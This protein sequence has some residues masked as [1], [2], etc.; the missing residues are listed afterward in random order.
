MTLQA[1][2]PALFTANSSHAPA[3][4]TILMATRNGEK[5][6]SEQ[7]DSI[8]EQT[9]GDWSLIV[10]DDGSTDATRDRVAAFAER[11]RSKRILRLD[12]PRQGSAMNF[13][14]LLRA[15]GD[16]PWVA[17][18]DQDDV[19]LPD[20]LSRGLNKLEGVRGPALYG[21]RTM[22]TDAQLRP[23]R[24][25]PDFS[26]PKSFGN[27]LVQSVAGGNTMLINRAA[28]DVLQPASRPVQRLIAHDW[29]TYQMITAI[30]GTVVYDKVPTV[31]SRQHTNNQI[32]ANDTWRASLRRVS[33][34]LS[35]EFSDW[36]RI[37]TAALHPHRG[38]MTKDARGKYDALCAIKDQALPARMRTFA[39]AGLYR[40]T[41]CG[42]LALWFAA[43]LGRL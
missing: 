36:C 28:L 20:R 19:W 24:L 37:Q 17:Y 7:L 27:A 38:R 18:C 2:E 29:W 41:P 31:L 3:H 25:S 39:R 5:T 26:R 30:G 40:Q 16:S 11:H 15:A 10:S 6:I 22:V 35:G 9:H 8:A 12:G 14:S 34:L 42:S 4:V 13:L 23:L 33:Q 1:L 21:A 32:G 43:V